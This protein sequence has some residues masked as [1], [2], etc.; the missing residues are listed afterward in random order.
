M[1][2][3]HVR[4]TIKGEKTDEVRLDLTEEELER[5]VLMPYR[6]GLTIT[7]NGRAMS[8]GDVQR[9]RISKSEVP[10][11]YIKSQVEAER[12]ASGVVVIGG[13]SLA[14]RTAARAND[15][16][17]QYVTGA[18][19]YES[20]VEAIPSPVRTEAN[21]DSRS[22]FLVHG[23]DLEAAAAVKDLL[24][25]LGLRVIE[26]EHAVARTGTPNPYVGDVVEAG[27]RLAQAAVVLFTGDD[28]VTLREGLRREGD[29]DVESQPLGQARPNVYYEAGFAD[30]LGRERTLLV[31][32]GDVKPFSDAAGRHVVRL[33]GSAA[34]RHAFASRLRLTGLE[35][36]TDGQDW[37]TAGDL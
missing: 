20:G 2:Y 23:R 3:Y 25:S 30:A 24:R 29:A 10:S 1:S 9:L 5:L 17:D 14:W 16:T 27:L 13:P 26:W 12:S 32:L 8:S 33:D 11:D 15:V 6:Q 22:V 18:P 34:K 19:G 21:M 31:E 35:V 36:D 7:L 28:M 37:L 4:V